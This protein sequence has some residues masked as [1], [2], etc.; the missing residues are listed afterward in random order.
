M[1]EGDLGCFPHGE[2]AGVNLAWSM[3][4]K[5]SGTRA[6]FVLNTPNDGAKKNWI[7]QGLADK[8]V[9][10]ANLKVDGDVVDFRRDGKLVDNMAI[11]DMG[12][13]A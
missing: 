10:I 9:V 4:L 2:I 5:L 8:A 3:T 1:Q 12:L 7:S 13:K 11:D 6:I